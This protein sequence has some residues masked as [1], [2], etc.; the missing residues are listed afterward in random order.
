MAMCVLGSNPV[1][2]GPWIP[3]LAHPTGHLPPGGTSQAAPLCTVTPGSLV[4]Q[5]LIRQI[6][7][8]GLRI[9]KG[10]PE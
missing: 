6:I 2:Q 1:L 3:S 8:R 5:M 7:S 9:P 10:I 4:N